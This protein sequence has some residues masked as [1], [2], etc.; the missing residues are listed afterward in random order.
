VLR[1]QGK[2]AEAR[3][4][5][6]AAARI[7]LLVDSPR[8]AGRMFAS[9]RAVHETRERMPSLE[10]ALDGAMSLLGADFGNVQLRDRA[11]GE[12]RIAAQ[13]GFGEDFLEH[14]A[15]VTD[16]GSACGRAASRHAQVVVAD[17]TEDE[18]FE[19]HR[20]IAA[21]SGSRAVLSTPVVDET[22]RLIG[23]VSTHFRQPHHPSE[24]DL[25]LIGWYV[26][27]IADA[28]ARQPPP[29]PVA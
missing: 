12:L 11:S 13:V 19:P 28:V 20:R 17:V 14:F 6:R 10:R 24:D 22:G 1:R 4:A 16:D 23:V 8:A 27:R 2:E 9:A 21:S 29:L 7:G 26:E 25:L 5:E 18:A 3:N 15:A